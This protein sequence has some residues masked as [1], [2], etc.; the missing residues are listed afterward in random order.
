VHEPV[1]EHGERPL[2]DALTHHITE[3]Q[4]MLLCSAERG[5]AVI[6]RPNCPVNSINR[7]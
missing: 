5:T 1:K 4:V 3:A 7:S 2:L 6:N